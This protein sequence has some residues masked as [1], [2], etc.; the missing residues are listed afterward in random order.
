MTPK[1][2][3]RKI[4]A[5]PVAGTCFPYIVSCSG[6]GPVTGHVCFEG[7]TI[8]SVPIHDQPYVTPTAEQI[9]REGSVACNCD[10][11]PVISNIHKV[12]DH[13]EYTITCR[14]ECGSVTGAEV[15][16]VDPS[17]DGTEPVASKYLIAPLHYWHLIKSYP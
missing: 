11:A 1:F 13:W 16:N 7:C 15:M 4:P 10:T 9:L 3:L 2:D 6:C 8:T 14:F 17:C 5:H 12:P